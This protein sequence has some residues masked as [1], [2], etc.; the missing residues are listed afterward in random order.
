MPDDLNG[1]V[2][3]APNPGGI[4]FA[5]WT[6]NTLPERTGNIGWRPDPQDLI[7]TAIN[8][9][10]GDYEDADDNAAEQVIERLVLLVKQL[11]SDA[12]AQAA[13]L[14]HLHEENERLS[15]DARRYRYLRIC[16]PGPA[17]FTPPG[18]FIGA[19]PE[20]LILTEKDAD[21]AVDAALSSHEEGGAE[22]G[23]R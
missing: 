11:L 6:Y 8:H 23:D 15:I 12:D 14:S 4:D 10:E 7:Y 22:N 3:P 2:E 1:A 5:H 17:D 19:V 21:A 13:H 9:V 16:D 20:N 18:L